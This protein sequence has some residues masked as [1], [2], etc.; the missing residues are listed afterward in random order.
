M[1]IFSGSSNHRLA[2]DIARLGGLQVKHVER[3]QYPNGEIKIQVEA[4][5]GRAVVVQSLSTPVETHLIEF[6]LICDALDRAGYTDLV[7][8]IPWLGYS[9]Q[10]KVF[11]PGEPLSVQVVAQIIQTTKIKKLITFDLHK[12]EIARF[13]EIPV[14]ELSAKPLF[15]NYFKPTITHKT[16]VVAPDAGAAEANTAWAQAL[17]VRAVYMDKR[18]DLSS[19]KVEI[20]GMRGEVR[21]AR[22]IVLDDMI[23]TGNTIM[24]VA[25][26]LKGQGAVSVSVAGTHYLDLEGVQDKI[27]E[28]GVDEIVV[29]DTV[30][31]NRNQEIGIREYKN[32]KVLSVARLVVDELR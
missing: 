7:G 26:Y 5:S 11:L 29:T 1:Q 14:V 16:V 22:V 13:F 15:L 9:K 31:G 25:K 17:G 2:Q 10:D 28:S 19:G 30:S 4:G 23:E 18:R 32:L 24:T 21:G 20:V 27:I 3:G 6:C 8:V 12:P